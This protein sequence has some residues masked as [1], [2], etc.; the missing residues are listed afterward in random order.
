MPLIKMSLSQKLN[1]IQYILQI[2]YGVWRNILFKFSNQFG[3]ICL[4]CLFS[5]NCF[6]IQLLLDFLKYIT[7]FQYFYQILCFNLYKFVALVAFED[8]PRNDIT[9]S[10]NTNVGMSDHF[11]FIGLKTSPWTLRN[12]ETFYT[13]FRHFIST[14]RLID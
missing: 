10:K 5:Q 6:K 11:Y 4:V 9:V 13:I 1:N 14:K 2:T 12:W 8:T 3:S 7:Q